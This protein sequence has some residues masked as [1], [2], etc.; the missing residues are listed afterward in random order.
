VI[1]QP[2]MLGIEQ[3]G[4]A[5]TM[6]FVLSCYPAHIQQELVNVSKGVRFLVI[7]YNWCL[8]V[9]N[10]FVTGGNTKFPQFGNRL[11]MELRAVRPFQS[12]FRVTMAGKNH[13]FTKIS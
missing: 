1:Y 8:F 6:Q 7:L 5:E 3:G 2:N 10:V 12:Q 11:E 13:N 9:Q 4:V